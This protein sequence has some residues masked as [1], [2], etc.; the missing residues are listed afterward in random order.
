MVKTERRRPLKSKLKLMWSR[1]SHALMA[2]T[3]GKFFGVLETGEVYGDED[4][5]ASLDF[6][7][8]DVQKEL[9]DSIS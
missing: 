1:G 2:E 6:C 4:K 7:R 9:I 8:S 5:V 3:A